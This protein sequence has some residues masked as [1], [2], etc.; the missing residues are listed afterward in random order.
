MT[1]DTN[2]NAWTVTNVSDTMVNEPGQGMVQGKKVTFKTF[3]GHTSSIDVPDTDFNADTVAEMVND[4]ATKIM[5]VATLN[6]PP[7]VPN[8]PQ[9][10]PETGQF[11]GQ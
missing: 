1:M 10:D 2:N 6:G 5:Q 7:I 4:A 9:Y 3:T 11:V 8:I